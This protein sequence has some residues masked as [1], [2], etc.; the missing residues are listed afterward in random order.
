MAVPAWFLYI[1]WTRC[2]VSSVV[3]SYHQVL[4]DKPRVVVIPC[5]I[6]WVPRMVLINTS[7]GGIIFLRNLDLCLIMYRFWEQIFSP[8]FM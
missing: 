7:K 3:G 5:I 1:L 8:A 6:L 4:V 2:V